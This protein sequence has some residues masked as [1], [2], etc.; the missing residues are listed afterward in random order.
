MVYNT[1]DVWDGA[2]LPGANPGQHLANPGGASLPGDVAHLD[3]V[4]LF[5]DLA[6]QILLLGEHGRIE[7]VVVALLVHGLSE[8]VSSGAVGALKLLLQP[9]DAPVDEHASEEEH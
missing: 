6:E 8:Q 5:D 7:P 3:T 9:G 1:K 4:A 2:A